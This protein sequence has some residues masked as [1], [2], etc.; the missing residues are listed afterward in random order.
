[1]AAAKL[2]LA[3]KAIAVDKSALLRKDLA[4]IGSL[5]FRATVC[6]C[7]AKVVAFYAVAVQAAIGMLV[8]HAKV[9][10]ACAERG[11]C[12]ARSSRR[13]LGRES[14]GRCHVDHQRLIKLCMAKATGFIEVSLRIH[15]VLEA[16]I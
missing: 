13:N 7:M 8:H 16:R 4:V 2:E 15:S 12:A 5:H 6:E 1:M 9:H 3:A 10:R 14:C 11:T